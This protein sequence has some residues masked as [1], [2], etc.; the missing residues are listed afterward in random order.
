MRDNMSFVG[1]RKGEFVAYF[2]GYARSR[3]RMGQMLKHMLVGL[4][5]V[6]HERLLDYR[7]AVTGTLFFAFRDVAWKIL[8]A[9]ATQAIVASL[10]HTS[11]DPSAAQT[12]LRIG[13]TG[14]SL[15]VSDQCIS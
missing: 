14:R 6:N 4:P 2:I 13:H 9:I 10:R 5:L 12:R 15:Q 8:A 7:K 11:P 1:A 3:Y